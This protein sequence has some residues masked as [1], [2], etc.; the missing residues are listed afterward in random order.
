MYRLGLF[1][2][3]AFLLV[4]TLALPQQ[5]SRADLLLLNA[6]VV[7]MNPKQP[8]AQAV[9]VKDGRIVWVGST[10]DARRLYPKAAQTID[11]EGATVLPGIIDAHTHLITLGEG[12]LKINLKDITSE[13]D[14]VERVRQRAA[15]AQPGEW[16]L[17]WGWDE[18]R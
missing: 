8:T 11:L 12:F 6:H 15:T 9:T 14:A 2:I 18:G 1:A 5:P 13:Q 4:T 16:I 3:T 10:Q 7:T 17:G